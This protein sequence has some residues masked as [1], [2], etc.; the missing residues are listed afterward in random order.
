MLESDGCCAAT[1]WEILR[2]VLN[3]EVT[4]RRISASR[5]ELN[6]GKKASEFIPSPPPTSSFSLS[7]KKSNPLVLDRS[8]SWIE[9]SCQVSLDRSCSR[10]LRRSIVHSELTLRN[11]NYQRIFAS[12][13]SKFLSNL[14]IIHL[15]SKFSDLLAVPIAD[16]GE[17]RFWS[18]SVFVEVVV[19][20]GAS[21]SEILKVRYLFFSMSE[22][23]SWMV[24]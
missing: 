2:E 22:R 12:S 3:L 4:M 6:T 5:Y 20:A 17:M 7:N 13:D 16:I 1:R 24:N 18:G 21:L 14:L 10:G 15:R 11:L 19:D 23:G 9:T 8:S